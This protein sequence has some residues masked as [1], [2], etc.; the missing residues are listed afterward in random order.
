MSNKKQLIKISPLRNQTEEEMI[1]RVDAIK[2]VTSALGGYSEVAKYASL[3]SETMRGW[4][5]ARR[6]K[7][8]LEKALILEKATNHACKARD[9]RPEIFE[10]LDEMGAT[11]VWKDQ[12]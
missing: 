10:L 5:T 9:L 11:I 1:K 6:L 3:T 12:E 8:S 4:G 2:A 7:P